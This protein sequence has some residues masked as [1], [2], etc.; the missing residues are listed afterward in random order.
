MVTLPLTGE[1]AL[2]GIPDYF[3]STIA[4]YNCDHIKGITAETDHL[5]DDAH[6]ILLWQSVTDDAYA[7]IKLE[8]KNK[9]IYTVATHCVEAKEFGNYARVLWDAALAIG[10]SKT[11]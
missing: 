10:V 7:A 4:S 11:F 3:D 1:V 8:F 2:S 6:V 5:Y 9:R